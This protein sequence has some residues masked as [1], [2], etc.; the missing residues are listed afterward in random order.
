MSFYATVIL[1]TIWPMVEIFHVD[2]YVII[3][4]KIDNKNRYSLIH[5]RIVLLFSSGQFVS[6]LADAE[7]PHGRCPEVSR[8][9][10]QTGSPEV[11][12]A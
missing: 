1:G 4:V 8:N 10:H 12:G 9:S 3:L 5:L 11:G 7:I 6:T 2:I